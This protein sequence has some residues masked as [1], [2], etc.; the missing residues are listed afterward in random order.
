MTRRIIEAIS[1]EKMNTSNMTTVKNNIINN[2]QVTTLGMIQTQS[3]WPTEYQRNYCQ[4]YQQEQPL[5]VQV[6]VELVPASFTFPKEINFRAEDLRDHQYQ[7][8]YYMRTIRASTA[9]KCNLFLCNITRLLSGLV[10][11]VLGQINR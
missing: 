6:V 1:M 9:L 10:F 5:I 7:Y 2:N 11:S 3:K 4:G 8:N